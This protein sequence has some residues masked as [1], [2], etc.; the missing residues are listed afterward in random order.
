MR[1]RH[2][3]LNRDR[4]PRAGSF[5]PVLYQFRMSLLVTMSAPMNS[6]RPR[7]TMSRRLSRSQ[8]QLRGLVLF[9]TLI[10]TLLMVFH[11]HVPNVFGLGLLVDNA[12]PW[13]GIAVPILW[14]MAL[15]SR[16]RSALAFVLI[17]TMAWVISFGSAII[18]L[19]WTAP[20]K[21][22][23][24]LSVSSQNVR[25]GT[26]GAVT[27]AQDL[28]GQGSDVIALQELES[29]S[30]NLVT[31]AL[32]RNYP[33]HFVVGTV[34]VWSKYPLSNSQSL[35][36]GLGWKRAL[37]TEVTTDSGTV[38]LYVVH[39]ASAR[40]SEHGNRDEMLAQLASTLRQDKS[41]RVIALGDFNATS[42]DRSFIPLTETLEEPNQ[43]QGMFG[44]TWP[45]KPFGFMRLDHV[46]QRGLEVFS[47]TVVPAGE[48]DHLAVLTSLNF[49]TSGS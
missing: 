18:P 15:F 25:A 30:A 44:F 37:R 42:T 6:L 26:G 38:R 43:D 14:L 45:R 23:Q 1:R 11:K 35:D 27:S 33:H 7:Q 16:S 41:P 20:A 2:V 9:G 36:L 31:Q 29:G 3:L 17:P 32:Q 13:F 22:T 40:A 12:A 24:S 39:A 21:T 8:R 10:S 28:S 48:S 19:S 47:N 49:P 4:T 34:G 46:L 5:L